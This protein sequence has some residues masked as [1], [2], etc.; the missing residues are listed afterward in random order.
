M[1]TTGSVDDRTR[2]AVAYLFA[3]ATPATLDRYDLEDDPDGGDWREQALCAQSDP[4]RWFPD[5]GGST[6]TAKLICADCPVRQSCLEY[7]L[8]ACEPWG[9]WGGKS[10]R[11]RRRMR[12][13]ADRQAPA[14]LANPIRA[15]A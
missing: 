4:D 13:D 6:R 7:A 15:A 9:V 2:E 11:E 3:T 12:R 14:A 1:D 5:R 8:E 10:E